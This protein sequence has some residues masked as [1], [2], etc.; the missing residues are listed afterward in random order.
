MISA[1]FRDPFPVAECRLCASDDPSIA[2]DA[3]GR[4]R[5]PSDSAALADPVIDP[6]DT[7]QT[8]RGFAFHEQH[9][10]GRVTVFGNGAP[11]LAGAGQPPS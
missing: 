3:F 10:N 2:S 8:T 5:D 7:T 4:R 6:F 9:M 1:R 11:P